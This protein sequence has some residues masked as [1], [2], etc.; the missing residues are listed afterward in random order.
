MPSRSKPK[1][2]AIPD[3]LILQPYLLPNESPWGGF[4]NIRLD[5]AQKDEFFA[6]HEGNLQHVPAYFD[7]MLAA[8]IKASFSYDALNQCFV[9]AVTGALVNA[10]PK[11]RYCSTSRASS[12]FEVTSL[13]VWKHVV[14]ARGDYGSYKPK[15]GG[16]LSFS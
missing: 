5:D 9:L 14:L 2:A 16:F 4:I 1:P 8:G 12:V 15:G 11:A 7:E 6:W 13:T 10:N 3:E